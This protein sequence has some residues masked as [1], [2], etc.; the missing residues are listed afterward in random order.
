[1]MHKTVF[2]YLLFKQKNKADKFLSREK[3]NSIDATEK[4]DEQNDIT[5]RSYIQIY[6]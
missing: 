2:L 6:A 4:Y 1:M 3:K 5:L